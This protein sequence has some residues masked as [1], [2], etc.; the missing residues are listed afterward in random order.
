MVPEVDATPFIIDSKREER[1]YVFGGQRSGKT[2][3]MMQITREY[4]IKKTAIDADF[5]VK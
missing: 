4:I 5:K 3:H 1:T 2:L